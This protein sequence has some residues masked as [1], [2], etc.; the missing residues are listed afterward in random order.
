M[1]PFSTPVLLGAAI[2]SGPALWGAFVAGSTDAQTA[3]VRYLVCA[4]LAWLGL[5]VVAM[6]VGPPPP[7]SAPSASPEETAEPETGTS[8]A[9]G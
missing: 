4:G 6:L 2:I 3:L 7:R 9:A 1:S 8:P 5:A